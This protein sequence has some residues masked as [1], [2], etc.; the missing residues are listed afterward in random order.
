MI[1]TEQRKEAT[2]LIASVY[3][4]LDK[5]HKNSAKFLAAVEKL[6][7]SQFEVYVRSKRYLYLELEAFENEPDYATVEKVAFNVVGDE[8]CHFYD[9]VAFPDMSD[10]PDHPTITT[11]KIFTGYLNMRRVQQL[12]NHKNHIPT[13]V[14]KIDAKTKQVS[15]ESKAA[16]ISDVEQFAMICQN[17][18][19]ILK[20]MFGPRGGDKVMQDQ[21]ERSISQSGTVSLNE[22]T[23]N[24]LNKAS[25]ITAD[26]YLTSAGFETNMVG[27]NAILPRTLTLKDVKVINRTEGEGK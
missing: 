13:S 22:L 7:N 26:V 20:E 6:S 12:V 15:F 9:Y 10:D 18:K 8:Y 25:M 16:R 3:D 11:H 1:T 23:D 21:M 2:D 19:N 5:T 27:K 4:G 14:D 17:N 24:R